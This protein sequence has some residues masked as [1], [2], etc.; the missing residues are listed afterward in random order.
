MIQRIYIQLITILG[1][2][3]IVIKPAHGEGAMPKLD[4]P[5]VGQFTDLFP[6]SLRSGRYRVPVPNHPLDLAVQYR[7]SEAT[8]KYYFLLTEVVADGSR[9]R[10]RVIDLVEM[11]LPKIPYAEQPRPFEC[12]VIS[13]SKSRRA[14]SYVIGTIDISTDALQRQRVFVA[15][16]AWRLDVVHRKFIELPAKTVKCEPANPEGSSDLPEPTNHSW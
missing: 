1:V 16:H 2:V 3:A 15:K 9:H 5:F 10:D 7:E 11:P 12:Y 13:E 4:T 14:L 8:S 6:E